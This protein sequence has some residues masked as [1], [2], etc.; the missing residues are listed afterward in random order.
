MK[1]IK[2]NRFKDEIEKNNRIKIKI[3]GLTTMKKHWSNYMKK[4][5]VLS[6]ML[7][8]IKKF[9]IHVANIL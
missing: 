6:I 2:E 3:Q 4:Y 1:K 8:R 7:K 9:D 5:K